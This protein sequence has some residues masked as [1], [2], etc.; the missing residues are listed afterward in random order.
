[1]LPHTLL[2]LLCSCSL[3]AVL[4]ASVPPA[5]LSL[6]L[7]HAPSPPLSPD[8]PPL[9][10]RPP[11][12]QESAVHLECLLRHTYE[13]KDPRSGQVTTTIVIGEV[14]LMHV[15]EGVAGEAGRGALPGKNQACCGQMPNAS[16]AAR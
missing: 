1:M 9:Q 2:W 10:V 14:V 16:G 3:T 13:V 7:L 6:L 11:R 8:P 15:H 5:F 4:A 12:V